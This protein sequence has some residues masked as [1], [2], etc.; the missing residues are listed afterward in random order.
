[1]H[2][3]PIRFEFLLFSFMHR[4]IFRFIFIFYFEFQWFFSQVC[5]KNQISGENLM[6]KYHWNSFE[7]ISRVDELKWIREREQDVLRC[8]N[9]F[10][11]SFLPY[12]INIKILKFSLDFKV[13]KQLINFN[14]CDSRYFLK[15]NDFVFFRI[16]LSSLPVCRS[17]FILI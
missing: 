11:S 1:M 9:Q 6:S 12:Y 8:N 4:T 10:T 14:R 7:K 16:V 17:Y 13:V 15:L 5:Q 2:A 3:L